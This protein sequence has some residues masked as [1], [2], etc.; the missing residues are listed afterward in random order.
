MRM[1]TGKQCDGRADETKREKRAS[2]TDL[3]SARPSSMLI[4]QTPATDKRKKR[5]ENTHT[6]FSGT[7]SN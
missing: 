1:Q 4:Q 7:L 2:P 5:L 6:S 3:F